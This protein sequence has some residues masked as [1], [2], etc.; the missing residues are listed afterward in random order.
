MTQTEKIA[1][2]LRRFGL[3]AGKYEV[4]RYEKLGLDGA[5]D[6]L[7]NY[8]KVD[9]GFPVSPWEFCAQANGQ[10][11][12]D[13]YQFAS[14]WGL[15]FLLTQR[16]LQERLTLF[17]HDH[18]AVSGAKVF[19]GPAMMKY[20]QTLRRNA[21]GNFR[22]LL[23]E[24]SKEP[25]MLYWLD[26]AQ[27]V[28]EHPNEN[29]ARELL[30]LF[31]MGSGFTEKDIKEA[32][33]AFTGWSV[34]FGGIGDES[35]FYKQQER[36]ARSGRSVFNYCF[37]PDVHDSGV[38]TILGRTGSFDG[39]AALDI[40][41]DRPETARHIT[42]KLWEWFAYASPEP[43]LREKLAKTFVDARLEVKPV[44]RAIVESNEFWS[45]RCVRGRPK[46]PVDFTVAI[47]RALDL[48]EIILTLRGKREDPFQPMP[49]EVRGAG[50]GVT[51]LM[52]AQGLLLHFPPDVG[53]WEWGESWITSNNMRLRLQHADL[54]FWGDDP[55]RPIA[56]Y[57]AAKI[58]GEFSPQSAGDVVDAVLTVF[59][60][61]VPPKSR[62]TLIETCARAGGPS[63][64]NAK[65][66]AA[67]M[68]ASVCKV[69]FSAPEFQVC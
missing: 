50:D 9:E 14:W 63:A 2:L 52:S 11:Q 53:G 69:L 38:K 56:A 4:A 36:A 16:P 5:I 35:E 30:E 25:A 27:S 18:F 45:E 60:G 13:P 55:A 33:R 40:L 43:K 68:L 41:A 39:D 62:D 10:L 34:H 6:R 29:F 54:M 64:L 3:G 20:Q 47:F 65:D 7:L 57:L 17:W 44:L 12:F 67:G 46:S 28:K 15:R 24:V 66:P 42:G 23:K 8:E 19:D 31:T 59:D 49:K 37:V 1:H 21:S 48:R 22:T 26:N 61:K 51:F 32:A 58:K